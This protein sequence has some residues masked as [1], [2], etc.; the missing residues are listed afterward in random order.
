MRKVLATT[1]LTLVLCHVTS[2]GVMPTPGSPTPP[3]PQPASAVQEPTNDATL[4]GDMST[5]SALDILTET[6]LDLLA[7]L[8]SLL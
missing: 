3:P 2:A 6:A 7:L 8:P 1:V 4:N 5:P